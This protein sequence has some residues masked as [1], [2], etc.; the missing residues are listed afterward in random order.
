MIT[1]S[2]I[3]AIWKEKTKVESIG[4]TIKAAFF[5]IYKGGFDEIQELDE[6]QLYSSYMNS[7]VNTDRLVSENNTSAVQKRTSSRPSPKNLSMFNEAY[8]PPQ[9][10]TQNFY[11]KESSLRRSKDNIADINQHE[12]LS[13]KCPVE[14]SIDDR[15]KSKDHGSLRNHILLNHGIMRTNDKEHF[16]SIVSNENSQQFIN[17]LKDHKMP[18]KNLADDHHNYP[19]SHASESMTEPHFDE[20]RYELKL[21]G[22]Q[23]QPSLSEECP[24]PR[25]IENPS[26]KLA[27]QKKQ[28][29]LRTNMCVSFKDFNKLPTGA[30]KDQLCLRSSN[31]CRHEEMSRSFK[32]ETSNHNFIR[33]YQKPKLD[34]GLK[35]PSKVHGRNR[36]YHTIKDK[37]FI[38]EVSFFKHDVHLTS[39][40][41]LDYKIR[42]NTLTV[43][44]QVY[45]LKI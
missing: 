2:L 43:R 22:P 27:H 5:E 12:P 14:H 39:R 25:K 9:I 32:T 30:A 15:E 31:S 10:H 35:P 13:V 36:S 18:P 29:A 4:D 3:D 28:S 41:K 16:D 1:S 21:P 45:R 17:Y 42:N 19:F 34:T 20:E 8:E 6:E 37:L 23:R 33:S 24:V 44:D 38:S 40:K 26:K 7:R 11:N